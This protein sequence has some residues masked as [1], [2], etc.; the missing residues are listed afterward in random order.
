MSI[1]I[2][3]RGIEQGTKSS[4]RRT[5]D[6]TDSSVYTRIEEGENRLSSRQSN[7]ALIC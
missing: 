4:R 6:G 3:Y 5:S 1:N 2:Q 7:T